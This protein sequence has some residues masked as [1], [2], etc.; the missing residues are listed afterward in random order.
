VQV[1]SRVE[2]FTCLSVDLSDD[3]SLHAAQ[4]TKSAKQ[5]IL[6]TPSGQGGSRGCSG[7]QLDMLL[8]LKKLTTPEVLDGD[9]SY[10]CEKCEC[11]R[12]ALKRTSL[13][14]LPKV[15]GISCAGFGCPRVQL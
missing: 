13:H 12:R 15:R 14:R 4:P 1:S 6:T 9:S 3:P 11:K 7:P 8:C 10:F 2:Q 5:S